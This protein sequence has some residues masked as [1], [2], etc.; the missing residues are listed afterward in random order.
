MLFGFISNHS[1]VQESARWL[2][3]KGRYDD[4]EKVIYTIA[5]LNG[6]PKPD[7]GKIMEEAAKCDSDKT[8]IHYT[9]FHLFK[10]KE[11]TITTCGLLFIWYV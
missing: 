11:L 8:S 1:I 7:T 2:V 6:K 10:T 5:K 9:A 4:A 3:T